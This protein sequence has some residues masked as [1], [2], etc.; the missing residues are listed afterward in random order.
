MLDV[1]DQIKY[2]E[3]GEEIKGVSQKKKLENRGS[4]KEKSI[5][6]SNNHSLYAFK[7]CDIKLFNNGKIQMTGLKYENPRK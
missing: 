7:G 2:I 5:L 1:D 3:N 6:Q 4:S